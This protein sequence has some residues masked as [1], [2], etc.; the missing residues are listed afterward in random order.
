MPSGAGRRLSFFRHL[1]SSA[2]AG[3]APLGP[4]SSLRAI[5]DG[6]SVEPSACRSCA[7]PL[8]SA[9]ASATRSAC[10]WTHTSTTD[11]PPSTAIDRPYGC[12]AVERN[13]NDDAVAWPLIDVGACSVDHES[14]APASCS[15][16][17]ENDDRS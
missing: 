3:A 4:A 6:S 9:A 10:D 1:P 7:P 2:A 16:R 13:T 15:S 12:A 14:S 11:A 5:H 17:R 8:R